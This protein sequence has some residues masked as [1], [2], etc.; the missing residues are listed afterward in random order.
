LI[1]LMGGYVLYWSLFYTGSEDIWDYMAVTGGIYFTGA[2]VVLILGLY[3]R[4]ASSFG[5][6]LGLLS[7][8]LMLLGLE[9]VQ[10]AVGLKYRLPSGEWAERLTS[11]QLGL[12]TV[13][14]A[15]AMTVVGSLL[16]PDPPAS[17]PDKEAGQ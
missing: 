7:G 6:L 3:W 5:A 14:I 11:P 17:A 15:V 10:V 2:F 1:V 12:L 13:G 16:R 8:L 4:G 9:P